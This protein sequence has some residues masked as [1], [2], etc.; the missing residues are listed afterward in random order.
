MSDFYFLN[1]DNKEAFPVEVLAVDGPLVDF[2]FLIT[3]E[4]K[5]THHHNIVP[6]NEIPADFKLIWID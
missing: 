6:V 3:R 2:K 1:A 4:T 5:Q